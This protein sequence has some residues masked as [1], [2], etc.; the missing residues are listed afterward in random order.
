MDVDG[1]LS[2]VPVNV[3]FL[4]QLFLNETNN[5][6]SPKLKRVI[7]IPERVTS[8]NQL[9]VAFDLAVLAFNRN[10]KIIPFFPN[11]RPIN[12][13]LNYTHRTKIS[14]LDN[15]NL[16][17]NEVLIIEDLIYVSMNIGR[18]YYWFVIFLI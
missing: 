6:I 16:A 5:T 18:L 9:A 11:K 13:P 2:D 12:G 4:F 15:K 8:R 10:V 17:F 14:T 3:S 1:S 7:D